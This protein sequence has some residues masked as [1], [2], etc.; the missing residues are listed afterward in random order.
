[1]IIA[2]A[3]FTA[4]SYVAQHIN[5]YPANDDNGSKDHSTC[6]RSTQRYKARQWNRYAP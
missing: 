4:D 3:I 2:A 6:D 5:K 1:M